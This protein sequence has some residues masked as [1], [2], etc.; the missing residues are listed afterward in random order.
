VGEGLTIPNVRKKSVTNT[1]GLRIGGL[2]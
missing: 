1:H 2:L